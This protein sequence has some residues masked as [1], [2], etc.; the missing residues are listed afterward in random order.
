VRLN[1]E[2][3][4]VVWQPPFRLD[5]TGRLK[6][7]TNTLEIQVATSMA[8]RWIADAGLPVAQRVFKTNDN[9]HKPTDP[10]APAGLVGPVTVRAGAMLSVR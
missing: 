5:V 4:G 6:P 10:L 8:N 7:G 3:L 9:P 2:D 1:G